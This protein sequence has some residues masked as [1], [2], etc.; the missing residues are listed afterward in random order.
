M[1]N[2][3]QRYNVAHFVVGHTVLEA[4]RITPR[5]SGAVFLIDTGMVVSRWRR[6]S[7]GDPRRTVHRYLYRRTDD[8][9]SRRANV[10]RLPRASCWS[11]LQV[12]EDHGLAAHGDLSLRTT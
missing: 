11:S 2:L 4:K 8:S 10:S 12:V 3:M 1:K 9:S 7:A 5:F 6:L